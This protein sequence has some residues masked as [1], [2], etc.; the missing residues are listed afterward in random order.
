MKFKTTIIDGREFVLVPTSEF[1]SLVEDS[2]E[3]GYY[4]DAGV[5]NWEGRDYALDMMR[6]EKFFERFDDIDDPKLREEFFE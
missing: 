4:Q 2:E 3:L 5:D 1:F 6:E